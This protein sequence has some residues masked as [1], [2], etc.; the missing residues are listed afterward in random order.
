MF[1]MFLNSYARDVSVN[2]LFNW[3]CLFIGKYDVMIH[4][5]RSF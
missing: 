1:N 5:I 2:R 4:C 3:M